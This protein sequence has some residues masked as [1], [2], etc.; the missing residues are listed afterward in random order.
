MQRRVPYALFIADTLAVIKKLT[1]KKIISTCLFIALAFSAYAEGG[2]KALAFF[3]EII[4]IAIGIFAVFLIMY[5]LYLLM[6]NSKD[7]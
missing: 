2:V 7:K 5:I 6:K 1:M 3:A 4:K